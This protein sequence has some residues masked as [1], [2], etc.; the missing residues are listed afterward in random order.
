[1]Q[2]RTVTLREPATLGKTASGSKSKDPQTGRFDRAQIPL[3]NSPKTCFSM[4]HKTS[5]SP[6]CTSCLHRQDIGRNSVSVNASVLAISEPARD[7]SYLGTFTSQQQQ[8]R[9]SPGD[10]PAPA[11]GILKTQHVQQELSPKWQPDTQKEHPG[12]GRFL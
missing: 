6:S 9:Q 11:L 4:R 5:N 10:D 2:K 12:S 8:L 3:V 7:H 1:M